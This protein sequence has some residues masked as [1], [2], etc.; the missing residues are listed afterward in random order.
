MRIIPQDI[1]VWGSPPGA[2]L[3]EPKKDGAEAPSEV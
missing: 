1:A 3:S 2:T